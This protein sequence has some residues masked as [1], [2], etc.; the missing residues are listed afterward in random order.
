M[1]T[2]VIVSDTHHQEEL[3]RAIRRPVIREFRM[4]GTTI[5]NK[6]EERERELRRRLKQIRFLTGN[7]SKDVSATYGLSRHHWDPKY[8]LIIHSL[9]GVR[10]AKELSAELGHDQIADAVVIVPAREL[11]VSPERRSD[12]I[13]LATG[14]FEDPVIKQSIIEALVNFVNQGPSIL[15]RLDVSSVYPRPVEQSPLS[16]Q[17]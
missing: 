9:N 17:A 6:P 8:F 16:A 15:L 5:S 3:E 13:L 1:S 12:G 10:I 4:V 11:K 7:C 14:S 2:V